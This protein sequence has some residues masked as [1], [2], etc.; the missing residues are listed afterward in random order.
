MLVNRMASF[1]SSLASTS[2]IL[3]VLVIQ[4][5][6]AEFDFN[7]PPLHSP[8]SDKLCDEINCGKGNCTLDYSKPFS[9][10]CKCEPGW[11]RTRSSDSE[12]LHEFLPCVIP[13]CTLDYSCMPAPPPIGPI[14]PIPFNSSLFDPCYWTYCGEGTCNKDDTFKHTCECKPGYANLMNITHFPCF[15]SCAIGNDC[16]RLGVRLLNSTSPSGS[17]QDGSQG[18]RFL[19]GGFH[20]IGIIVTSIAMALWN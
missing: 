9:F 2:L 17:S 6:M 19:S 4:P 1:I 12:D 15:S 5:S 20:W 7:M 11:R 13:N 10:T 18:T 14:P 3:L 8:F 16:S